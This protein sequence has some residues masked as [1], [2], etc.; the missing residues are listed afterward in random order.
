[1]RVTL[2]DVA[3]EAGVSVALVS[4]VM[5]GAP[6]AS[7]VQLKRE[8]EACIEEI[9]S[10]SEMDALTKS[11]TLVSSAD[12]HNHASSRSATRKDSAPR[13][14]RGSSDSSGKENA[15]PPAAP[16]P[17][18]KLSA[19]RKTP[20]TKRTATRAG[21]KPHPS[22]SARSKPTLQTAAAPPLPATDEADRRAAA[23]ALLGLAEHS[24]E[25]SFTS[26]ASSGSVFTPSSG[27]KR[28]REVYEDE[29]PPFAA[30]P[31]PDRSGSPASPKR[32]GSARGTFVPVPRLDECV[33]VQRAFS[34]GV[35]YAVRHLCPSP[36]L[37]G[38]ELQAWVAAGLGLQSVQQL[39]GSLNEDF[40]RATGGVA[41]VWDT[42]HKA[43]DSTGGRGGGKGFWDVV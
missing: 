32:C 25:T 14:A 30:R 40:S 22:R 6:G 19:V 41:A 16:S 12:S 7:P 9:H 39:D 23:A 1:M 21:V 27:E 5:R 31:F 28:T 43:L 26:F 17:A 13:R 2:G 4:I 15:S 37:A 29:H 33:D 3:A 8:L 11:S 20:I 34:M 18:R 10:R 35:E 24:P 42:D 38:A 36:G